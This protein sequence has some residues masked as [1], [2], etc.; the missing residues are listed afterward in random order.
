[1]K[2]STRQGGAGHL[3]DEELLSAVAAG[4]S[5][6]GH[7]RRMSA[8]HLVFRW[9]AHQRERIYQ[10]DQGPSLRGRPKATRCRSDPLD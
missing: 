8:L 5:T 6:A 10:G 4:W 7:V 2:S 3:T 9:Q 1:M